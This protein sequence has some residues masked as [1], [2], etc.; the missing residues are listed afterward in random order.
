M[1]FSGPLA[2]VVLLP[3]LASAATTYISVT[4]PASP[5]SPVT[6]GSAAFA[7]AFA[8]T[9]TLTGISI[10]APTVCA[11]CTGT[12]F[13]TNDV[14]PSA[15]LANVFNAANY[16]GQAT[17][18]SGISLGPGTYFLIIAIESGSFGWTASDSPVFFGTGGASDQASLSASPVALIPYQSNFLIFAPD[19]LYTLTADDPVP[20]PEP[21]TWTMMA[22]ALLFGAKWRNVRAVRAAR[23]PPPV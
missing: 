23:T 15:T 8:L 21:A 3:T 17:L 11:G 4:G 13:L 12:V 16:T 5:S 14:G 9:Q 2:L 6:L 19:L 18:F 20:V 22:T 1:R 7:E 10:S